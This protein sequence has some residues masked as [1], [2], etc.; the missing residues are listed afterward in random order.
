MARPKNGAKEKR[1][2]K[3]EKKPFF[4]AHDTLQSVT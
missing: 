3:H 1:M 4:S 2:Q